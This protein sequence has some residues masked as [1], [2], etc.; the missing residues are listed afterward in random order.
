MNI[1]NEELT[2]IWNFEER[3]NW[4]THKG[5]YPGNCSPKVIRNLLLKYSKVNDIVLDQFIGS[6]TTAIEALLLNR[7]VIGIDINQNALNICNS[8]IKELKGERA[9]KLGDAEELMVTNNSID[10]IC[11]HP[12]YLDIIKYSENIKNDLSLL[13]RE[14]FYVALEKVAKECYRVLKN[15]S[16]C[17]IIIGD[18]RKNGFIEPLGFNVMTKFL[19]CG[20]KLKEIIIKEQHNCKS[21]SKWI[22]IAK[23]RNFLLI[24]HEY[25]FVFEKNYFK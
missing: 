15:Q 22:E 4:L 19:K 21:T 7:K 8:R 1:F 24:K 14:Q 17:A 5:D 9:I 11:T 23:K 16:K 3:G 12:P 20:F 6:G 18:V 2:S 25:I 13:N 10:F